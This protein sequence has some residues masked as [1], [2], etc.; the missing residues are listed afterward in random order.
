M[1]TH[2]ASDGR[3]GESARAASAEAPGMEIERQLAQMAAPVEMEQTKEPVRVVGAEMIEAP[4]RL[5]QVAG[6]IDQIVDRIAGADHV[7]R[8]VE[9]IDDG[10]VAIGG[11][12]RGDDRAQPGGSSMPFAARP[13]GTW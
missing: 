7:R 10:V 5:G 6:D 11:E 12:A 3:A 8:E 13:S 4:H 2:H 1:R 9:R